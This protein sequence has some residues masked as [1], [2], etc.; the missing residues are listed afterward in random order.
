MNGRI[1]SPS[2]KRDVLKVEL[3]KMRERVKQK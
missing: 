3:E 1:L 2:E